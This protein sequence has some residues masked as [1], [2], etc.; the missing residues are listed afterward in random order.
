MVAGW[1]ALRWLNLYFLLCRWSARARHSRVF[2]ELYL[3]AWTGLIVAVLLFPRPWLLSVG[4]YIAAYR[5]FLLLHSRGAVF[6]EGR[7]RVKNVKAAIITVLLNVVEVINCFAVIILRFGGEWDPAVNHPRTALYYSTVTFLTLGYGDIHPKEGSS[8]GQ[9][10]VIAELFSF[11][12]FVVM[13][14]PLVFTLASRHYRADE[15]EDTLRPPP[16]A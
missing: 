2:L 7:I 8:V 4:G 15:N 3:V 9:W 13:L 11:L 5:L 1:R 16:I 6:V 10:I 14:G 12:F